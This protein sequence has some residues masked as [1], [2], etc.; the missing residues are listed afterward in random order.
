MNSDLCKETFMRQRE[1]LRSY[2]EDLGFF[3]PQVG[4]ASLERHI[5][6]AVFVA[7]IP[8]NM[9]TVELDAFT[10]DVS[11]LLGKPSAIHRISELSEDTI[12]KCG[13]F[14]LI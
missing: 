8:I 5:P 9:Q 2:F 7:Q 1:P 3:K 14:E 12:Q 4:L 10:Q 13:P 11:A 6:K